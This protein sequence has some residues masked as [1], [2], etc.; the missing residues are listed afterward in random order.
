MTE[1]GGYDIES[2]LFAPLQRLL[3]HCKS[4][5]ALSKYVHCPL[6][7]RNLPQCVFRKL[8]KRME[9]LTHDNAA[10]KAYLV[11]QMKGLTNFVEELVN[12]GISVRILRIS[13]ISAMTSFNVAGA[14]D[15]APPE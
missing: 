2:E 4:A 10:L 9:D 14:T 8:A 12:F 7:M 1:L 6:C 5:K 13:W 3:D 15:H 11:P